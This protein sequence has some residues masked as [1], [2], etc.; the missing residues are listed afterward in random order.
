[1][2]RKVALGGDP[3]NPST[4]PASVHTWDEGDRRQAIVFV[5]DECETAKGTLASQYLD[6]AVEAVKATRGWEHGSY[7][8]ATES[9]P[10]YGYEDVTWGAEPTTGEPMFRSWTQPISEETMV[11]RI[12]SLHDPEIAELNKEYDFDLSNESF[13]TKKPGPDHSF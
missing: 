10:G 3:L 1:M 11:D 13:P 5:N 4:V 9:G 8:L 7:M 6:Q 2:Y 12:S